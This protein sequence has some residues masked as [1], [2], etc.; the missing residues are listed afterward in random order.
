MMIKTTK[1]YILISVWMT[2][3]FIQ[4]QLCRN[5][6]KSVFIFFQI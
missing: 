3:T 6:K 2:L 5:K 4:R 1:L